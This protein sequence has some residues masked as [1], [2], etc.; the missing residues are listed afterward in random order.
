MFLK[1]LTRNSLCTSTKRYKWDESRWNETWTRKTWLFTVWRYFFQTS[2]EKYSLLQGC[3]RNHMLMFCVFNS[4]IQSSY[5]VLCRFNFVY[6]CTL[7]LWHNIMNSKYMGHLMKMKVFW[8]KWIL[9]FA[10]N[11]MKTRSKA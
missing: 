10:C 3:I 1:S 11:K 8:Y 7:K 5:Y 6:E 9:F 2:V 4:D